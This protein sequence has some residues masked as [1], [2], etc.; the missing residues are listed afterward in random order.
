MSKSKAKSEDDTPIIL[1]ST[2]TS[3]VLADMPRRTCET[4][5]DHLLH[6]FH[7]EPEYQSFSTFMNGRH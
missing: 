5:K 6:D 2:S 4:S 1:L 7:L 3:A